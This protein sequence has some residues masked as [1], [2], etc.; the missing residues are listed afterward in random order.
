M[1]RIKNQKR[2]LLMLFILCL[3]LVGVSLTGINVVKAD[4]DI[5]ENSYIDQIEVVIEGWTFIE[6]LNIYGGG[7]PKVYIFAS[8]SK[9]K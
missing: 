2:Q 7:E 1:K 9:H 3:V 6:T 8:W 4:Y 5:E